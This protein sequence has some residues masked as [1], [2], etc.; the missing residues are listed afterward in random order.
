MTTIKLKEITEDN[1]KISFHVNLDNR[2]STGYETL[3][4]LNKSDTGGWTA[5][6]S[7]DDMPNQN[8]PEDAIER[9]G[10]YCRKMST[11]LKGK[12]IKHLS[13]NELFN[14]KYK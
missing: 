11:A 12:N 3:V 13:I 5:I 4:K 14:P 8:T 10:L 9:L 2:G 6:I 7:F 1:A